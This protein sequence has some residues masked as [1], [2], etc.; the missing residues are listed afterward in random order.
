MSSE[1]VTNLYDVMDSAYDVPQIHD[2][3]RQLGHIP[4]IDVHPRRDKALKDELT[5][6]Q[7]RC[8]LVG[9]KTNG[10]SNTL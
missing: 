3:C 10:R 8:R 5:A 1:R 6:E 7:K 2:M 4:L 9:H